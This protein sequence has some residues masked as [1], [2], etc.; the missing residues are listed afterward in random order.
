MVLLVRFVSAF[1]RVLGMRACR[2]SPTCSEYAA[3][4]FR[5]LAFLTALR[6]SAS[7]LLRCHPLASGGYDPVVKTAGR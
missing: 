4:A 3:E 7:R 5:T 2:Y 1:F 6:R